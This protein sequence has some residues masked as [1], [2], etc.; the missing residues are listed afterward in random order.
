MPCAFNG[1]PSRWTQGDSVAFSYANPN[2]PSSIWGLNVALRKGT[3]PAPPIVGAV[4]PDGSFTFALSTI[5]SGLLDPGSYQA[6]FVATA[7]AQRQ[8]FGCFDIFIQPDP[9]IPLKGTWAINTLAILQTGYA[10]LIGGTI[11]SFSGGGQSWTK[12]NIGELEKA[13]GP[14][15]NQGRRR[16]GRTGAT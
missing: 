14:P 3:V 6:A 8:T 13:M 5:D 11:S 7:T 10:G 2:F 4:N 1:V 15:S 12:K 9:T 16:L